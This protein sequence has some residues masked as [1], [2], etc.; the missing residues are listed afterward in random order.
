MKQANLQQATSQ[1]NRL[2]ITYRKEF[3]EQT[4]TTYITQKFN[5]TDAAI[6][7]H[8]EGTRTLGLKLGTQGLA[9]FQV[10]DVDMKE[11][12]KDVALSIARHLIVHYGI[13]KNEV[14]ISFSGSK[15]Y[16]VALFYDEVVQDI[17]L[18]KLYNEVVATLGLDKSLVEFRPTSKQG[19]KL[20]LG[21][22]KKTD[23]YMAFC[24]YD[25]ETG[26]LNHLS[27]Q[28][29]LD[30]FTSIQ[31]TSLVE[32]KELVLDEI[33]SEQG[34][35]FSLKDKQ[36][37]DFESIM[38]EINISGKSIEEIES[39]VISILNHGRL[40]YA[41]TRN[42]A[43]FLLSMFLKEQGY[44]LEETIQVIEGVLLNTYDNSASRE[45]ISADTTREF[46]LSEV[47][48]V[49]TNTYEKDYSLSTKRREIEISKH[50]IL[51][52]LE[53]KEKH[54]KQLAFSFLI[55]SKRHAKKDGSFYLTYSSLGAM[56]NTLNHSMLSKYIRL[57]EDRKLIEIQSSNII[58]SVQTRLQGRVIK[59]PNIYKCLIEDKEKSPKI[60]LRAQD[61]ANT[62]QELA[63][64][65]FS[66]NEIKHLIPRRQQESFKEL[67]SKTV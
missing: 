54:L 44:E 47:S 19:V 53:I 50:E 30:Y 2:Y 9:K 37:K 35:L 27:R 5:L 18:Y 22:H 66:F 52:I 38:S 6:R 13:D 33:D 26:V 48:R 59:K 56:G 62:Y 20:P 55:H 58:D 31:P 14:H 57:L 46:L 40:L 34:S 67:L 61:K 39:E 23:N 51:Q 8:L 24:E 3:L 41:G 25:I 64:Q 49:A 17:T 65:F 7:Q 36:A 11:Q 63:L 28:E 45:L 21:L 60:T 32:F 4:K 16:H 1:I 29:S 10:F 12:A 43:T 42:R 15:G